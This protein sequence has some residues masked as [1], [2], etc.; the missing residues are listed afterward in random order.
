MT[1]VGAAVKRKEDPDLL[2]GR[3]TFVDDLDPPGCVFASYVRS[4]EAHARI[5]SIDTAAAADT[6]GVVAVYTAADFADLPHIPGLPDE[7]AP[8]HRPVIADQVVRYV[9]DTVAVVVA[10]DRYIAADAAEQV[11]VEYEPLPVLAS[12]DASLAAMADESG[13]RI[14]PDLQTNAL[15]IIPEADVAAELEA[16]PRRATLRIVNNRCAATPI[17]PFAVIADWGHSGMTLWATF[18]AP[19]HLRNQ[20]SDFFDVPH[21][22]CRVIAPDVG[23]G[24][25]N[26]IS[27]YPE[28]FL[29]PAISKR[30]HRPVKFA[31]TR[32][33]ALLHCNHGRG[34]INEL[35]VGFD[36]DGNVLA[37]RVHNY[38]DVGAYPDPTGMGLGVLTSWMSSGVYEIP[39][40]QTALTNVITN[41]TPVAAYR[42]AG[43]PERRCCPSA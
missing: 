28:L 12:I 41:T 7:V 35:D 20:L 32:S 26:K 5:V 24:F 11:I 37:L 15:P 13:P 38:Q 19:H 23:G 9:G 42:G 39:V 2:V 16:A 33:E 8:L 29:A 10:L 6:E 4:P 25:G 21:H 1:L 18:Q 30:L 14:F 22:Q 3:G 34:Q 27:F 17:E 40:V 31:Q 43:R 36:D